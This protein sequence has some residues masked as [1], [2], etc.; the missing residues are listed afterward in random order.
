MNQ[1]PEWCP[2]QNCQYRLQTQDA[3]CV[4]ELPVPDPHGPD[5]NTHRL[6]LRGAEDDGQWAFSM[7]INGSDAWN[8]G[9]LLQVVRGK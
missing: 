7:T 1:R 4:G 3:A 9:R 5:F 8:L 6:C 2:H